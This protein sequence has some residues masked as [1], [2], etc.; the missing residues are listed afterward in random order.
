M[1]PVLEAYASHAVSLHNRATKMAMQLSRYV[2]G[3]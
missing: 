2:A 1:N 3:Q